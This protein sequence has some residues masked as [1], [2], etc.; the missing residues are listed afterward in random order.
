MA[1]AVNRQAEPVPTLVLSLF[2]SLSDRFDKIEMI[3]MTYGILDRII[4]HCE[5]RAGE[6]QADI[7]NLTGN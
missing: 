3:F 6:F 4:E 5:D 1:H 7:V 2:R